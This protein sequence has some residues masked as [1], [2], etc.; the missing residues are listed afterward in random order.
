MACADQRAA[1]SVLTPSQS[2]QRYALPSGW[3]WHDDPGGFQL[4]LPQGWTRRADGEVACFRDPGGGRSFQVLA[5]GPIVADAVGHWAQAEQSA[6]ADGALPGYQ[7][8][9]MAPLD[10]KNGGADWEYTWQPEPGVRRHERRLLLSMGPHR[11]YVM[12]WTSGDPDW[13]TSE[14]IL[15]LIVASLT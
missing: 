3:I 15:Q 9:G 1:G 7:R 6:L 5:N 12:D 11:A 4:A 8:I 2:D 14:P 10:L 13:A